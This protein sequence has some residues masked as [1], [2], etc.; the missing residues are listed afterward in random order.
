[1]DLKDKLE[2]L[3]KEGLQRLEKIK[4]L[5]EIEKLRVDYLG[6]KGEITKLLRGLKH[7][8]LEE[9]KSVGAKAN[10]LKEKLSRLIDERTRQL[11]AEIGRRKKSRFDYTLPGKLISYGTAHPITKTIDK[12]S[13]FFIGLGYKVVGGPEAELD[14][15]NFTAL[16]IPPYHPARSMWDTLYLSEESIF[17][18]PMSEEKLREKTKEITLLRTHTSPVQIRTMLKQDPPV[19]IIAP[20]RCYRK[21][22]PDA[23][24][25]PVFHQVEGLAVDIGITFANLK[26]TLEEF[27][28]YFFGPETGVRF[29]PSYFPFTEPSA[30][31]DVL[32]VLCGGD[33][34]SLCGGSGWLEILGSG[35]VHPAV[36]EEVGYDSEKYTGFAFGMGVERMVMLK[37]GIPDIRMFLE[38]DRRFLNQF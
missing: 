18:K 28:K 23:S 22:I 26:G 5:D 9:R 11:K 38:N 20:G 35:M 31:V 36:L 12:I 8:E 27:S 10:K 37:Y 19:F 25:S 13:S 17:D 21:D 1:M 3:E 7:L 14:Y 33:G 15:F 24:H 6:R 2:K 34:C 32:C 16:N 30:E 29:R 4:S